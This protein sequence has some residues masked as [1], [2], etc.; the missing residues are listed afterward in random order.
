LN[1][2]K[3][4]GR[5]SLLGDLALQFG[6]T[7][8]LLTQKRAFYACVAKKEILVL[9]IFCVP[10]LRAGADLRKDLKLGELIFPNRS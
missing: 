9:C 6:A 7:G 8:H 4:R 1:E 3:V 10:C 2:K 5:A